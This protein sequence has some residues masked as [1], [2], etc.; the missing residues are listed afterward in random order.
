[1]NFKRAY[2]ISI[3]LFCALFF[4]CNQNEIPS[5]KSSPSIQDIKE[6]PNDLFSFQRSYPYQRLDVDA[7][8]RGLKESLLLKNQRN[9]S[10]GFDAAWT[11]VG[12]GNAGGRVNTIAIHPTDED[13]FYLGYATG[14]VFKTIDGGTSW[15][16]IFDDQPFLAIADI[17]LDP[18]D[19]ETIYVGTGDQNISGYPAIGDG[20][21]KSID[22]G[23][24]WTHLGLTDQ[25]IVSKI[26]IDPTNSNVIYAACMGLPFERN[27]DR[28]LYKSIDGG[29]NWDQVLFV[30]NQSGIIDMVI[31][32]D[33]PLVLY[34]ASWDRI[35]NNEESIVFGPNAKIHKTTDGGSTWTVL[36]NGLPSGNQGRIGLAISESDPDILVCMYVA[37]NQNLEG[38]YRTEDAG[39]TWTEVPT[40]QG[41]G[42]GAGVLGGFGW[43]FGQIRIHPVNDSWLYLLG[44]QSWFTSSNGITWASL[45]AGSNTQPH[46]DYHDLDFN[47]QNDV[48]VANDGGAYKKESNSNNYLDVEN[49]PAT[50]FYRTAYDPHRPNNYYGGTQDNGTQ[51]GMSVNPNS[52]TRVLGGDG[53]QM[54]FHPTD[55]NIVFAETQNGNIWRSSD[56]LGSFNVATTG[57]NPSD[58][59]H[60]DMQYIISPHDP[61]RM[62]TGTYRVYKSQTSGVPQWQI[63]SPDLTDGILF[64]SIF[65]TISTLDESPL[66][67][68]LLYVGTTDANVWRSEDGGTSWDSLHA[69]LPERYITSIKASPDF[70]DHVYVCVSGYRYNEFI[71]RV[72]K[73]TDRGDTWTSIS[74]DLP[75]LAVNDIIILPNQNDEILFVAT[76]GGVFASTNG[77]TSW[78][79]LGVNMPSVTVYDMEWN[80]INNELVAGTFGRSIYAYPID[81]LLNNLE[82]TFT[83][84][85]QLLNEVGI[86]IDS[87]I[88]NLNGDVSQNNQSD[89]N[90]LYSLA[91][92]P[93][94]ASCEVEPT[95][96]IN[97]RNG[98]STF[99]LLLMQS[100]ILVVD[101][102]DSPYKILAGDLNNSN[103]LSALDIVVGRKVL[104]FIQDTFDQTP[105]WKFTTE[106]FVF[107]DAIDPF[108]DDYPTTISCADI[109]NGMSPNFIGW[110]M[111]DVTG[112]ANPGMFTS[113]SDQREDPFIDFIIEDQQLEQGKNYLI[114]VYADDFEK[115]TGMQFGL[116]LN[117]GLVLNSI[118]PAGLSDFNN[119]N[120]AD[121]R[122]VI[123]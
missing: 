30:S 21:Y 92:V 81:S 77:G 84:S 90:G 113:G 42:M 116:K 40:D 115:I 97:I 102:L 35:R 2:L 63:T 74:G 26:I 25:R 89:V 22:G 93:L 44:V 109:Q 50:Q 57:L 76:D 41:T 15:D 82:S 101:T 70:E 121:L 107:T 16:P 53:F 62:Y 85:G 66:V 96:D 75:D 27:D 7:Y 78:E 72:Y 83:I 8:E 58:R 60:W 117:E 68:D 47:F 46:V 5:P 106:D 120:S 20:I 36:D 105:S 39:T 111:G 24:S 69:T 14:G 108:E 18:N 64:G 98:F 10:P 122:S 13:V 33:N 29:A 51:R 52:W 104:L 11:N 12:P 99:D 34:A 4:H 9:T 73:S 17:A 71:P 55:S 54:R 67:E 87:A 6:Y 59:R 86:G 48:F 103:S 32:P 38:I 80:E 110:K 88:V 28:G 19:A 95:K 61:D 94:S 43:Y 91:E 119:S 1:M 49:I 114:P 31:D 112:N 118:E 79:S 100:H 65:H 56:G 37:T 45:T 123:S 3:A 23:D